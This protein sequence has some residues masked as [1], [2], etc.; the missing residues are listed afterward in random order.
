LAELAAPSLQPPPFDVCGPLPR[1]VTVLE[2]SAGTGK[3]YTIAAL[4]ARYIAEG[5]PIER[6]L[7]VTFTRIATG[8]L[9]ERVRER[10]AAVHAGLERALAGEAGAGAAQGQG[11][12]PFAAGTPPIGG[13]ALDPI[14]ALL[15]AGGREQ[16][17]ARLAR[18]ARAL[19]D[20]DAAT[21]TTTHGFCQEVL[22]SLGVAADLEPDAIFVDD[23]S[24]LAEE[25]T[26]DL[27]V[28][29]YHGAAEQEA[30]P[31][32]DALAI[33]R[34][35]TQLADAQLVQATGEPQAT[36][37][38]LAEAVRKELERRKR[39][40]GV[41]TYDDL[42]TRLERSL[43][44]EEGQ[45][46]V[47]RLRAR[48]EIV[49]VDEFQDTDRI[50]WSI[51]R[52]A[53]ASGQRAL[54]LIADPK[55]AIYAFRGADVYSYLE[56]ARSAQTRATLVINW[57]ADQ[58]LLD[59]CDQLFAGARLGH[60]EIEYRRLRAAPAHQT[61]RL[62]GALAQ[63]PL[64]V[65]LVAREDVER[66]PNGYAR[67]PA[68][69]EHVAADLAQ[70]LAALLASGAVIERR[71][72]S[73]RPTLRERLAPGHAAV[74]VATN[75]QAEL[76]REQ[77]AKAG[78]PAVT[79]GAGSVFASS[80]AE[81]W[82]VLL[83]ALE[84]PSLTASA[85]RAAIGRFFGWS[86]ERLALA[87]DADRER[88]HQRLHE[89]ARVLRTAGIASL[90]DRVNRSELLP[91][92]V[93]GTLGG[94]RAL[95]DLRH[96]GELLH[97]EAKASGLG[98]SALAR[99]LARRIE[100][101]AADTGSE[102]RS[103]RLE[104]DAAAV[105]VLTIHRSKGLEF[106]VV[107]VPFA[108][109]P[110]WISRE[111]EPVV[112]HD[113]RAEDRR[114]LDVTLEGADYCMHRAQYVAE[115]RG[116][117]L[118]LLYVALTR[119]A[120]Q[121][122]LWW[123]GTYDSRNSALG[124][125]LFCRDQHG[126]VAPNGYR[127]LP[128]AQVRARF[129]ALAAAAKPGTI[130]VER[131]RLERP[132]AYAPPLEPALELSAAR[133][134][135]ALD[136][137]WRRTSYSDLVRAARE[138]LV[139]SEPEEPLLA[140]EPDAEPGLGPPLREPPPA[141]DPALTKQVP[142]AALGTGRTVGTYAHLVLDRCDFA[143]E[144]LDAELGRALA[145]VEPAPP[146]AG[147]PEL[148]REGL[149]AAIETP[150]GPLASEAA[151]RDIARPQR[152]DELAFELPLAGG[153]R[154]SGWVALERLAAVLRDRLAPPDP[155]AG[156]AER[157]A[158]PSLRAR[159]RGYLSGSLDL[160]AR[161][162]D[163]RFAVLDYKTNWLGEVDGTLTAWHHRPAALAAEMSHRHY[164]LQAVLYLIALYRFLRW[165]RPGRDPDDE[166]AGVFYLFVRGML[167]PATPL[168]DGQRC[169]IFAWR[170]PAGLI[171]AL[172]EVLEGE[173]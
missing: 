83:Y 87:T 58:G 125:L 9:R 113:P 79:S 33:A 161:L 24:G 131:S 19:A 20:F 166:L 73:G 27:Y 107:F 54:I 114:A 128:D 53:F 121:A 152:I 77:L 124:R 6:L 57:R 29:R 71:D 25:V 16:A 60:P 106:P 117:D 49:L 74:L 47:A 68:A 44:G 110:S 22:A 18:L 21:I 13:P 118:R 154:P 51:L 138:P 72:G 92:R 56:A 45:L 14:V 126:N 104:S 165:R 17:K 38:R 62:L 78:V 146:E 76:V 3:T 139:S 172:S 167:G 39:A 123:A 155:L 66:T 168:V 61:P 82:L 171:G 11:A 173:P 81:D 103:R 98:V 65:R 157:L 40:L 94:E 64:R 144:D 112:F 135:R 115:Q 12:S 127:D 120:Q 1:G 7:L 100:E 160:V 55:Q 147:P 99:W 163:G 102:E 101:A 119:A 41:I 137:R 108:W 109:E 105:Q 162:P 164:G 122:V 169:G 48:F 63:A 52:H 116:E 153:D 111:E 34:R 134:E 142:L 84:R 97:A 2:A 4:A 59:A 95:T 43:A 70:E 145:E 69:R 159:V 31:F 8:E 75:R 133:F 26:A 37:V 158:D 32:R 91:E 80:A 36:R 42:L 170:P 88:L 96:I 130:S 148:L 46:A 30:L 129:E 86:P 136:L 156:Y 35:A 28:R 149:R 93:L 5:V 141:G 90:L 67:A 10:L 150:L 15:C 50:Q 132:A 89:L 140:D 85:A 143:A 23:L 151:L